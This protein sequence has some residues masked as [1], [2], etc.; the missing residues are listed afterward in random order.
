MGDNNPKLPPIDNNIRSSWNAYVGWLRQK[1]IAGH[2][3]LDKGGLG[4]ALLDQYL[5]QNQGSY[6]KPELIPAIQA[7]FQNL[8]AYSLDQIKQGKAM[9][10]EGVNEE[11]FMKNL[12]DAD[13]YP[14][15]FT[16]SHTYPK[17]YM[18]FLDEKGKVLKTQDNG[19][20]Q[21]YASNK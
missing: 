5:R 16:T 3:E 15:Q 18:S 9:F 8:K 13:G 12:S 11:N 19:F 21:N 1:G 10:A 14:G 4:H 20:V 7:D 2:P 17:D 6:L